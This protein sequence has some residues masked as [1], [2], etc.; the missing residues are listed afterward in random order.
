MK[1]YELP[2]LEKDFD[3]K[4]TQKSKAIYLDTERVLLFIISLTLP[5]DSS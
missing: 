1:I 5:G 2:L 3:M 4:T